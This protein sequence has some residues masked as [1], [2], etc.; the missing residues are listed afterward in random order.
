MSELEQIKG[1]GPKVAE[2]L[3][4]AGITDLAELAVRRPEEIKEILK[5]TLKKA[6]D[7]C[8]QAQQIA[9]DKAIKLHTLQDIIEH[10]KKI[11][12]RISTGSLALDNLLKGGIPTEATTVLFGEYASGK[13]QLCKQLAVN[14]IKQY[15]RKVAWIETESGTFSP[16]RILE[17]AKANNVEIDLEKDFIIIPASY[18]STPFNQFL[19]YKLIEKECE[20]KGYDLGLLVIDSFTAKFRSFYT[21]REQLPDRAKE[22]ARHFGFLDR[23]ASKFNCAVV[24]T[25]QATDVP[26]AQL[27]LKQL[28]KTGTRKEIVGGNIVKHS[29]TYL[30]ALQKVKKDEWECIVFDAPD[31]PMQSVRFRILSSGIK[32]IVTR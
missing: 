23:I 3:V 12:K 2:K 15:G 20:E 4:E 26:D 30:L 31:I 24:L 28:A 5:I 11:T 7:I 29:G 10:K 25:C 16:D 9:L 14:C 6:K 19:A 32:D 18:I 13:T 8:N 27:Q 17:I 22:T 21:G 1:I